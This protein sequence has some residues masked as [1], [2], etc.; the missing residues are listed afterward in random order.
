MIQTQIDFEEL[1]KKTSVEF[2]RTVKS[3]FDYVSNQNALKDDNKEIRSVV[4]EN[5]YKVKVIICFYGNLETYEYRKNS[6]HVL[7]N[8]LGW[9]DIRY[10]FDI[11][12]GMKKSEE[13][14]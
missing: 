6:G 3:S 13:T 8:S 1:E 14:V 4:E 9:S 12:H 5:G 7:H 2:V 10:F 11:P